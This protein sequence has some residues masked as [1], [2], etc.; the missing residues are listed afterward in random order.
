MLLIRSIS[1][2]ELME[3]TDR[4]GQVGKKR[5]TIQERAKESMH[6]NGENVITRGNRPS[7]RK[8]F[9]DV[10]VHLLPETVPRTQTKCE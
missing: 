2:F 3:V 9:E 5:E 7:A 10:Q 8:A 4:V 1:R 6:D